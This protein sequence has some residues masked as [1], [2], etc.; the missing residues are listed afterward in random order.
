MG[1]GGEAMKLTHWRIGDKTRCGLDATKVECVDDS[2]AA[3]CYRCA[4]GVRVDRGRK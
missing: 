4:D 3:D 1:M 2:A